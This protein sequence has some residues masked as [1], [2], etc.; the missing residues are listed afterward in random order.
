MEEVMGQPVLTATEKVQRDG[1]G[2]GEKCSLLWQLPCTYSFPKSTVFK[3]KCS[4][5]PAASSQ[6][7][8]NIH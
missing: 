6:L 3:P 1:L 2:R 5:F 8:M 7:T 4:T